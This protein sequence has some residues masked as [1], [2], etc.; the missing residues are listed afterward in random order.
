MMLMLWGHRTTG[1]R[2]TEVPMSATSTTCTGTL[3]VD[4][5]TIHHEIRGSGPLLV[6]GQ[7]GEGD[8]RR[9]VDLVDRLAADF[10]VLTYDRRGLSRSTVTDPR[11]PITL[12][13]HTDDLCRLLDQVADRPA[14]MLGCSLGAAIGLRLAARHPGRLSVLV[15]H[16]PVSPWL[17]PAADRARQERE[18]LDIRELYLSRGLTEAMREVARVLGIDPR[19]QQTEPG[20]TP[21]PM[22]PQRIANFDTFLRHDLTAIATDDLRPDELT[23]AAAGTRIIP[24]VGATTATEVFDHRCA[25]R[26]AE[27]LAVRPAVLPGGH[28]GNT[29]H[30]AGYAAALRDIL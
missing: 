16:E 21:Q 9:T 22:T 14:R 8:A 6:I 25:I 18:L 1:T 13:G 30:P 7:S 10:T 23:A 28:N 4:G 12:A 2:H 5:A 3:A 29:T 20:L 15:A 17:L 24:A 11:R 26:L 19:H 27:R